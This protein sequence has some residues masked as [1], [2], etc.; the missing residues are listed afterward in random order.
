MRVPVFSCILLF[1]PRKSFSV[2]CRQRQTFDHTSPFRSLQFNDQ[3]LCTATFTSGRYG[4]D[5]C[6]SSHVHCIFCQNF[7]QGSHCSG[8]YCQH[9]LC[10]YWCLLYCKTTFC[11]WIIRN[12]FP[13]STSHICSNCCCIGFN[14]FSGKLFCHL[15]NAQR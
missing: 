10:F 8:T 5:F 2:S 4:D 14:I 13:R 7:Y 9:N 6:I 11:F 15:T 3:F 1:R 12:L